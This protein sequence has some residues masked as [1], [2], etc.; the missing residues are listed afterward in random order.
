MTLTTAPPVR[1]FPYVP[2]VTHHFVTVRG[3]R[4]HVAEA[5]RELFR[6]R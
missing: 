2:G 4:L 3:V 6:R 5:A 1:P